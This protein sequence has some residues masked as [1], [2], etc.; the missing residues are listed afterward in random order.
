MDSYEK[1]EIAARG[2]QKLAEMHQEFL[3]EL[4]K[5]Q[6]QPENTVGMVAVSN[7]AVSLTS[8]GVELEVRHRPIV[9]DGTPKAIEYLA[10]AEH[11]GEQLV[12]FKFYLHSSYL[13]SKDLGA[14][15]VLCDYNNRRIGRILACEAADQ[16]L[17]SPIFQPTE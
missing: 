2:L 1:Q 3:A 4:R 6:G 5:N 15:S 9:I 7:D 13:L 10:V 12:V 16:L 11:D 8:L 17:T 14:E